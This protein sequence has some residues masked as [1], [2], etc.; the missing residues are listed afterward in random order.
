VQCSQ[1]CT[2]VTRPCVASP[3]P[4]ASLVTAGLRVDPTIVCIAS[5]FIAL[6]DIAQKCS[7]LHIFLS[8]ESS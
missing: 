1:N 8:P 7:K 5:C 3:L 6:C 4:W 2:F